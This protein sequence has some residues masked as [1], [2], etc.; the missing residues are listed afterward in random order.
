VFA[1]DSDAGA[2]HGG[3]QHREDAK[4]GLQKVHL[5]VLNSGGGWWMGMSSDRPC[6]R[7]GLLG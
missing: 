3:H 7:D 6:G 2:D 1:E 5:D 4:V